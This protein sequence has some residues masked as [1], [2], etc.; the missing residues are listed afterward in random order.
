M[1]RFQES[2]TQFVYR[3]AILGA[4]AGLLLVLAAVARAVDARLSDGPGRERFSS[5]APTQANRPYL[6][7][8]H[9]ASPERLVIELGADGEAGVPPTVLERWH[10]LRD[11]G[12]VVCETDCDD[13]DRVPRLV[14]TD[15][16]SLSL[17]KKD[18]KAAAAVLADTESGGG[19]GGKVFLLLG[20][21]SATPPRTLRELFASGRA[22]AVRVHTDAEE[23]LL[24][25][26]VDAAGLPASV[27]KVERVARE[28]QLA[29]LSA[30]ARE[31]AAYPVVGAWVTQDGPFVSRAAAVPGGVCVVSYDAA[32][33]DAHVTRL[34]MPL[35]QVRRQDVRLLLPKSSARVVSLLA[36]P[37]LI[38]MDRSPREPR[39]LALLLRVT[40]LGG[41]D[42]DATVAVNT[43]YQDQLEA[44]FLGLTRRILRQAN[45]ELFAR[46]GGGGEGGTSV[47]RPQ[48]SVLEQ[49]GQ[50]EP[51]SEPSSA[52]ALQP[53]A[54]LRGLQGDGGNS[55]SLASARL[56]EVPL[57]VG[58][59]V[60]LR[61]Q[62]RASENGKYIVT[63]VNVR[64]DD[65][66]MVKAVPVS[67]SGAVARLVPNDG[68]LR[69]DVQV[70]P[71]LQLRPGDR[72][73]WLAEASG[74]RRGATVEAGG[75]S[76]VVTVRLGTGWDS[77]EPRAVYEREK[78]HPKAV[79][80]TDSSVRIREMCEKDANGVWDRP[81]END[82][83]CPF[84]QANRRY[85]NYRGG[86]VAGLCEMPVGVKSLSFRR[87]DVSTPARCYGGACAPKVPDYAFEADEFERLSH[88]LR[89]SP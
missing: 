69:Y 66:L 18:G 43:W 56:G 33:Q 13:R 75:T 12:I 28:A 25:C 31:G 63:E 37:S 85:P 51:S 79:C 64:R 46:R 1:V 36:A 17:L 54:S 57:R 38:A 9:V 42:R 35:V 89:V 84:F 52:L 16:V 45:A 19:D 20:P 22:T 14:C 47:G 48:R 60:D 72:V 65:A 26:L 74:G 49:F 77:G 87:Y 32:V 68:N 76:G 41:A 58:D 5:F 71:R 6:S 40:L 29:A 2:R 8:L 39:L 30:P 10:G 59:R 78:L 23:H 61:Y 70:D 88:G 34:L 44:G 21:S 24:R 27:L 55:M 4:A 3:G 62:A 7:V 73:L 50:S 11:N 67:G 86:C 80:V 82:A 81:C 53:P 15:P 83:E